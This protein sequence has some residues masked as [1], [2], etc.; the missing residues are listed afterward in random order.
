M[1]ESFIKVQRH[2]DIHFGERFDT[3]KCNDVGNGQ[4][5]GRI[6]A[7]GTRGIQYW[8]NGR[9]VA[10]LTRAALEPADNLAA[11]VRLN[12]SSHRTTNSCLEPGSAAIAVVGVRDVLNGYAGSAVMTLMTGVQIRHRHQIAECDDTQEKH[13]YRTFSLSVQ[14]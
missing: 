3:F 12:V 5:R 6:V 7:A 8:R 2:A 10:C 1:C 11:I 4:A 14:S 9:R 13:E